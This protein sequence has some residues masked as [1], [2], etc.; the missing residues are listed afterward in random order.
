MKMYNYMVVHSLDT[1]FSALSDP[2]RRLIVERLTR[3]PATVNEIA[4]PFSLSQQAISKHLAYLERARIIIKQRE[5]RQHY[6]SLKPEAIQAVATWAEGFRKL[7]EE[8]YL[9][10]DTLL[11]EMKAKPTPKRRPK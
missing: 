8:R 6:C 7:W 1:T 3:G 2:T 10:L 9:R 4:E 5:G 11:E